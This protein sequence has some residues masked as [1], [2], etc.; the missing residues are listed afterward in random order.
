MAES[1][2]T[3]I[4]EGTS[5]EGSLSAGGP[6]LA[7]GRV[8]GEVRGPSLEVTETGVVCGQVK[9]GALRSRGEIGGRFEAEEVVLGGRLRDET[10]IVTR[11]LE[12]TGGA[13]ALA[14]CELRVGDPPSKEEAL[15]AAL[16]DARTS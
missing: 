2:R 3:I 14:D 16:G 10:V 13:V 5:F 1:K 8:D 4:E 9:V 15:R 11:T 6:I 7:R 12:V